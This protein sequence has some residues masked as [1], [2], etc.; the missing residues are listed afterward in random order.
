MNF[1]A[2]K[3]KK[4]QKTRKKKHKYDRNLRSMIKLRALM[5]CCEKWK[6]HNQKWATVYD[7]GPH[8]FKYLF[9]MK[10]WNKLWDEFK[11][12]FRDVTYNW[13]LSYSF[14][15]YTKSISQYISI[16]NLDTSQTLIG[17]AM[18]YASTLFCLKRLSRMQLRVQETR[19][20]RLMTISFPWQ[21][22]YSCIYSTF[23][24]ICMRKY[25]LKCH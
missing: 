11:N 22:L 2:L 10:N 12:R 4:I 7:P 21:F 6:D 8:F 20:Q 14:V 13:K 17:V 24:V 5:H 1:S 19:V 16:I 15:I 9:V 18:D 3:Q 23:S 25:I